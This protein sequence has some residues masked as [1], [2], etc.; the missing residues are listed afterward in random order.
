MVFPVNRKDLK[1]LKSALKTLEEDTLE[2]SAFTI[3]A[4][5]KLEQ[6]NIQTDKEVGLYI[7]M[8]TVEAK[9][10]VDLTPSFKA[11]QEAR[12]EGLRNSRRTGL[13]R[14]GILRDVFYSFAHEGIEKRNRQYLASLTVI[15]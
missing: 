1:E 5:D 4:F 12:Y 2:L 11:A 10:D 8:D 7:L 9:M 14:A 3:E 13:I 15:G 6:T